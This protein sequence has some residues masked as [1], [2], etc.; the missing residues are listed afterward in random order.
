MT[1]YDITD[2]KKGEQGLRLLIFKLPSLYIVDWRMVVVEGENFYRFTEGHQ[3]RRTEAGKRGS[4][5]ERRS[6]TGELS[7]SCA[8]PVA[9]G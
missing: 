8:R 6:L 1:V 7:L 3:Y 4:V 5:V 9:D 2:T